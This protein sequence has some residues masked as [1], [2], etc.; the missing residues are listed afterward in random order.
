V[1]TYRTEEEQLEALRRWWDENGR[2]VIIGVVLAV[3][4]SLGWQYWKDHD[5]QQSE[6]ASAAY[7]QFLQAVG[8]DAGAPAGAD[9]ARQQAEQLKNRY[10]GSAYANFA[11]LHLARLAAQ[12]DDLPGA[13]RELRWVLSQSP[14]P[15]TRQVTELRL[16]RVMA[17]QGDTDAALAIIAAAEQGAYAAS[18]ALA[19][20][21]IFL[22]AGRRDEAR[23]AYNRAS[24]LVQQASAGQLALPSL[25][26]KIQSLS[27]EP[28]RQLPAG[29][30]APAG[31]AED[32]PDA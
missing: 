30:A 8:A 2:G 20:G 29:A 24:L 14:D 18:Y 16:A 27:P 19:E 25:Q 17:A 12:G 11:A 32:Q 22:Q 1:D 7:Q 21:D 28:A 13:E 15:D 6:A 9:A 10:A 4:G 5:R 31:T 23:E 3:A 26:Q